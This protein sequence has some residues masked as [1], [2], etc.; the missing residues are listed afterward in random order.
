M[1]VRSP[2]PP[3]ALKALAHRRFQDVFQDDDPKDLNAFSNHQRC[4]AF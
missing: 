3:E 4:R 2:H 1:T